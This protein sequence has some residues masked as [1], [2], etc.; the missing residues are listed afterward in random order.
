MSDLQRLKQHLLLKSLEAGSLTLLEFLAKLPTSPE[1]ADTAPAVIVRAIK[2][3]GVVDIDSQPIERQGYLRLLQSMRTPAWKV[4]DHVRGSQETVRGIV[5]HLE[6]ASANGMQLRQAL[7]LIGGPGCG[8]SFLAEAIKAAL[9]GQIIYVLDGC[10]VNENPIN[11]LRL[12]DPQSLSALAAELELNDP[13]GGVTLQTLLNVSGQPCNTCYKKVMFEENGL[14]RAQPDLSSVT[15]K[16]IRLSSRVSGIATWA[17]NNSGYSLNDAVKLGCGGMLDIPELCAVQVAQPGATMETDTLIDATDARRIP[18]TTHGG[19][20]LPANLVIIGQTNQGSWDAFIG[21]Q[22][23]P[24]KVTRRMAIRSVPYITAR[25]EEEL[26]YR[27]FISR[28][29]VSPFFDPLALKVAATLAVLSRLKSVKGLSPVDKVRLRNGETFVVRRYVEPSISSAR[30]LMPM[31][32]EFAHSGPPPVTAL[33]VA[34][35][36]ELLKPVPVSDERDREA[37]S[38]LTMSFMLSFVGE[39][40]QRVMTAPKDPEFPEAEPT[41]TAIGI[42]DALRTRLTQYAQTNGLTT[43]QKQMINKCLDEHLKQAKQ[44]TD[45]PG[46]LELEYRRLLRE[47]ILEVFSPDFNER[48]EAAFVKY[49]LHGEAF[50]ANEKRVKIEVRGITREV[51]VDVDFLYKIDKGVSLDSNIDS[52]K[53]YRGS[54]NAQ[55]NDL[56]FSKGTLPSEEAHQLEVNWTT[57]PALKQAIEDYLNEDIAK[58]VERLLTVKYDLLDDDEKAFYDASFASFKKLGYNEIS[59]ARAL[60]YAKELKLWASPQN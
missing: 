28:M 18:D 11:I 48:A 6:A 41:V 2:S 10:P 43:A 16:K 33:T 37:M 38:G 15:V 19:D 1:I 57:L 46:W 47:Q 8:K 42:I 36:A 34:E 26:A 4:F 23:D 44:T 12:V 32:S 25:I 3:F 20:Y 5:A 54:L 7:L 24:D 45:R 55:V 58:K 9:E 35:I 13:T 29:S 56:M 50:N 17:P 30:G 40:A 59:L 14:P 49:R 52:V 60:D 39:V 21:N 22:K 27:D 53:A 51:N 31:S